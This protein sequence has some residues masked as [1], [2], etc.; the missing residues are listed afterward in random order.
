[1]NRKYNHSE[2]LL[3][4]LESD[5][6][7]GIDEPMELASFVCTKCGGLDEVPAYVVGEF[8]VDKKPGEAVALECPKCNGAMYEA[9][10]DPS[11]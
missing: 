11:E 9:K 10:N 2:E 5:D 3:A 6:P 4:W 1:M 7:F 8:M